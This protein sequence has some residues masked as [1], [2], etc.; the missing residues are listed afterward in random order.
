VEAAARAH[1]AVR[2]G[3]FG[4]FGVCRDKRRDQISWN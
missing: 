4:E 1:A 3:G 2:I